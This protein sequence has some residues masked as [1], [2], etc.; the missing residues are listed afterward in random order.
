MYYE[1]RLKENCGDDVLLLQFS[2][3]YL[4]VLIPFIRLVDGACNV[5]TFHVSGYNDSSIIVI[6][7]KY[8]RRCHTDIF[9]LTIKVQ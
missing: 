3:V 9:T 8:T 5:N 1:L 2:G 7:P 4:R 6:T